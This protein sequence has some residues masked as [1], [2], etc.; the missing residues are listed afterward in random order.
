MMRVGPTTH[1]VGSTLA[2][3]EGKEENAEII[4]LLRIQPPWVVDI[5]LA[6][7]F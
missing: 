5:L 2:T 1:T 7:D 6:A 3:L 4:V